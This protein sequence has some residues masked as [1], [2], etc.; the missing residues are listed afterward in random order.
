MSPKGEEGLNVIN[1]GHKDLCQPKQKN[2]DSTV[3]A[4]KKKKMLKASESTSD[5]KEVIRKRWVVILGEK[6]H[7]QSTPPL[8]SWHSSALLHALVIYILSI[9]TPQLEY[10]FPTC[11]YRNLNF[12]AGKNPPSFPKNESVPTLKVDGHNIMQRSGRWY[13]CYY[14]LQYFIF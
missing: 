6:S 4:K 12:P 10:Y 9:A 7:G 11:L 1:V 3:K 13:Y 8:T 14:I 5:S 2:T